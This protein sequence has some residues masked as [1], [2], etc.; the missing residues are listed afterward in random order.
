MSYKIYGDRASKLFANTLEHYFINFTAG[1]PLS[2]TTF[3]QFRRILIIYGQWTYLSQKTGSR[4]IQNRP[5]M[6]MKGS[7]YPLMFLV[8]IIVIIYCTVIQLEY[9]YGNLYCPNQWNNNMMSSIPPPPPLLWKNHAEEGIHVIAIDYWNH[10]AESKGHVYPYL[11]SCITFS[12]LFTVTV[13]LICLG[14]LLG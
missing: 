12:C 13:L 14:P 11:A 8:T 9:L 3:S 10:N 5:S 1:L 6:M 2:C 4:N 7:Q